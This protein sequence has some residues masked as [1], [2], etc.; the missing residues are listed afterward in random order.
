MAAAGVAVCDL[1]ALQNLVKRDPDGYK[2]DFER[3]YRHF[4]ALLS[5]FSLRPHAESKEFGDLAMF[6]AHV[7]TRQLQVAP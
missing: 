3:Q 7:G 4:K 6:L 2:E 5:V 1:L